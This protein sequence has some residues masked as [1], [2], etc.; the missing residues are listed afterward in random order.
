MGHYYYN[1]WQSHFAILGRTPEN[2]EGLQKLNSGSIVRKRQ[3]NL[4]RKNTNGS[5]INACIPRRRWVKGHLAASSFWR[6][7]TICCNDNLFDEKIILRN[8]SIL[9]TS[10]I[11]KRVT[12]MF[13]YSIFVSTSPIQF[14]DSKFSNKTKWWNLYPMT[15]VKFFNNWSG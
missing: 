1:F 4:G 5:V 7:E 13:I 15:L 14:E 6:Q 3:T 8:K 9:F 2:V 12:N 10:I 11:S